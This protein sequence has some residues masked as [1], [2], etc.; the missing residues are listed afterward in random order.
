MCVGKSGKTQFL[1]AQIC[2]KILGVRKGR[3]AS[4]HRLTVRLPPLLYAAVL[5]LAERDRR[6]LS[7]WIRLTLEQ[8]IAAHD[9]LA[10]LYRFVTTYDKEAR[11]HR[12]TLRITPSLRRALGEVAGNDARSISR[13]IGSVLERTVLAR[14]A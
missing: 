7:D 6:S 14:S 3:E 1:R 4:T 9:P 8:A 13:W 5:P 12:L 2:E 10:P 11:D